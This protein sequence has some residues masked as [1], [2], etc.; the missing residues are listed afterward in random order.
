MARLILDTSV[1]IAAERRDVDLRDVLGD[2]DDV[3]VAS[4]TVAELLAGAGMASPERRGVREGWAD[5]LLALL[6]VEAYDAEA[7]REHAALMAHARSTGMRAG[8]HDLMIAAV[9][10]RSDREV[11]TRDP[12]GFDLPGVRARVLA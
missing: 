9:A 12:R 8:A 1:L 6:P 7:A 10:V 5:V 4:V 2:D 3:A 11:V